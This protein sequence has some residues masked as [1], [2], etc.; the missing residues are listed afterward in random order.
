MHWWIC[1]RG[2][3]VPKREVPESLVCPV[4]IKPDPYKRDQWTRRCR[5]KLTVL[6]LQNY[7]QTWPGPRPLLGEELPPKREP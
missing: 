5:C 4:L 1:T 6:T 2:H 3:L 7:D